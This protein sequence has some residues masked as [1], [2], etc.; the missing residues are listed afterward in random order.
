MILR[1]SIKALAIAL[2]VVGCSDDNNSSSN[3]PDGGAGDGGGGSG[4]KSTTTTGGSSGKTGNGGTGNGGNATTGGSSGKGGAGGSGTG[5]AK[6]SGGD[7]GIT[8]GGGDATDGGGPPAVPKLGAQIDRM[9]R[10]AINTALNVTFETDMTVKNTAKDAYNA[11]L[12]ATWSSFI[13]EFEKNLAVFDALDRNCGNQLLADGAKTDLTR[14][15]PLA[16]ALVDDELYVNTAVGVC[17]QYLAVELGS[18]TDC[19]GRTPAE[20]VIETS[21]SALAAGTTTGV[22]D[23]VTKGDGVLTTTFPFLSAVVEPGDGGDAGP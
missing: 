13:P 6:P 22:D 15:A 2:L 23:G 3:N 19:G 11:A 5:G 21:Y 17:T 1:T 12:P 9:G 10:P 20:D 7:A 16:T 8:D 18:K 14:Y 4:G